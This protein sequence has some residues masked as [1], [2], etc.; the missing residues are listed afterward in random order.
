MKRIGRSRRKTR[1][2]FTKTLRKKGKISLT[3]Y[4]QTFSEGEQVFLKVEPAI[5]KGMYHPRFLG[6]SG[7]IK[8]KT[9]RCYEVLIKDQKKEKVLI[10]H[11]VHMER[12]KKWAHQT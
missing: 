10:V 1:A 3:K 7:M 2:K 5:Q 4:F 8:K 12:V 11:P 9:G 6:K